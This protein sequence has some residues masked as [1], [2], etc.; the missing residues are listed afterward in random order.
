MW[1]R[2]GDL[3]VIY[4]ALT[5]MCV[6]FWHA[7]FK[8]LEHYIPDRMNMMFFG[9]GIIVMA[10]VLHDTF[11]CVE[12]IFEYKCVYQFFYDYV[13][14][15]ACLSYIHGCKLFYEMM[16]QGLGLPPIGIA[17]AM[18]VLL[19]MMGGFRNI[20]AL[21]VVVNNDEHVYRYRPRNTLHFFNV[22]LGILEF[23][24]TY[25]MQCYYTISLH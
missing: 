3:I 13:I 16:K 14:V 11:K 9:Y 17:A 4:A 2:F 21:P 1:P 8:L 10:L 22:D 15:T 20:L 6:M 5:P 7:T 24:I 18:A 23:Y 12:E 25:F 19:M